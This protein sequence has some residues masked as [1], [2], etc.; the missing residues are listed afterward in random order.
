[1]IEKYM[2]EL[3]SK[4]EIKYLKKLITTTEGGVKKKHREVH[5]RILQ[6]VQKHKFIPIDE[7]KIN[8]TKVASASRSETVIKKIKKGLKILEKKDM[9]PTIANVAS[10][11][12]IAYCTSKRYSDK[13]GYAKE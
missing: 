9:K 2:I 10:N 11:A 7:K 1:M 6:A 8:R 4:Q 13:F 12:K 3:L 5:E